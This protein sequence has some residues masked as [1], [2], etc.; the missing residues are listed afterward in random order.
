[1]IDFLTSIV[2]AIGEPLYYATSAILIAWHWLFALV[3]PYGSGFTWAFAI[4]GLTATMRAMLIPLFVRQIKASR[5][6][7]L[8][9]PKVKEMQK[10][11][12]HDRQ[13]LSQEQMK[14][15]QESGTNPFAA[16]L[17]LIL[18]APVFFTLFRLISNA[19]QGD[20]KGLLTERQA[21]SLEDA[22]LFGARIADRFIGADSW[23]VQALA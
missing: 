8:L 10:K 14:L 11:Y 6:M 17:P 3:L 16:C 21:A 13:R 1:M 12:G 19:A 20:P 22:T 2:T 4:V 5:N 15:Y 18:Q 23:H 9:Q 7:Q